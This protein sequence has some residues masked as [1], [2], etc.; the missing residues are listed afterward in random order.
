M[1]AVDGRRRF[2]WCG[3]RGICCRRKVDVSI[4]EERDKCISN[5]HV[6]S[7]LQGRVVKR[8]DV[9]NKL[10]L[11]YALVVYSQSFTAI[12]YRRAVG[13]TK[14]PPGPPLCLCYLRLQSDIDIYWSET[15]A[16]VII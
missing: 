3:V 12:A 4:I 9:R 16:V 6:K 14:I 1:C 8:D 13:E 2:R 10:S 15:E 5:M 11:R 7:V